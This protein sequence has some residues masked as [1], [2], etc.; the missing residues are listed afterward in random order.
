MTVSACLPFPHSIYHSQLVL[1]P[2]KM[3][4]VLSLNLASRPVLPHAALVLPLKR[5]CS[6]SR[7]GRV[8]C[9]PKLGVYIRC[10]PGGSRKP[11][12]LCLAFVGDAGDADVSK[13]Q[14][15]KIA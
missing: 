15:G 6:L 1:G 11:W 12:R 3:N 7:P 9:N 8:I 14:G 10:I 4:L 5:P 13:G 2:P